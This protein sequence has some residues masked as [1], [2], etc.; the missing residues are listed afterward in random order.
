M[1]ICEFAR[2]KIRECH[3][4]WIFNTRNK[5][6]SN[7]EIEEVGYW[8]SWWCL[9]EFLTVIRM[10]YAGQLKTNFKVMILIPIKIIL[11]KNYH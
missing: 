3:E 4:F 7:G 8:D 6:N 10:K 11:L 1:G 5:L 2:S 9:G